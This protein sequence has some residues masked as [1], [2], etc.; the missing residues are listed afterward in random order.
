MQR[1]GIS[2]AGTPRA[3][4]LDLGIPGLAPP[5]HLS[6]ELAGSGASD[7]SGGAA[8]GRSLPRSLSAIPAGFLAAGGT[9]A[10]ATQ[11]LTLPPARGLTRSGGA[12]GWVGVQVVVGVRRVGWGLRGTLAAAAWE[13]QAAARTRPPARCIAC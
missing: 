3:P 13:A 8:F 9:G 4:Q 2:I 1:S 11:S 7:L 12:G 10:W 5:P 6:A